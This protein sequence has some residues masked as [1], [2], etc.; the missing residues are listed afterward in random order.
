[1]YI[2]IKEGK[3]FDICSN[4]LNK[5]GDSDD[6]VQYFE[7]KRKNWVIGDTWDFENKVSLEDAPIRF[8]DPPKTELELLREEVEDLKTRITSVESK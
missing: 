6:S 8:A 1:M 4:I 5:R 7:L 2:G 3:I